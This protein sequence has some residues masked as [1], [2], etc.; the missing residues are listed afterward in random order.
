MNYH[1]LHASLQVAIGKWVSSVSE[2]DDWINSLYPPNGDELLA[3]AAMTVLKS[4][5]DSAKF[6]ES[7]HV[8]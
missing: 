7:E 4:I 2:S 8:D 6:T 5:E 3:T 1:S